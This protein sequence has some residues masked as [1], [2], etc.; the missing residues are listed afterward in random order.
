M[1]ALGGFD[2][3]GERRRT[4]P[5]QFFSRVEAHDT[6][7]GHR[8]RDGFKLVMLLLRSIEPSLRNRCESARVMPDAGGVREI[9]RRRR[10]FENRVPSAE[11][12]LGKISRGRLCHRHLTN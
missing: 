7:V 4:K 10:L 9:G 3:A 6:I 8:C 1:M 2:P 11:A 5:E 12:S